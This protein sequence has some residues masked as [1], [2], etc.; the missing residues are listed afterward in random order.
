MAVANNEGQPTRKVPNGKKVCRCN[1]ADD[2]RRNASRDDIL[3]SYTEKKWDEAEDDGKRR[4]K[5]E[6]Y[7]SE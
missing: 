6:P 7:G 5:E 1:R 2:V 3:R 4:A